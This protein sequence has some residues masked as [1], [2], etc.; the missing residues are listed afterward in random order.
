MFRYTI[1]LVLAVF[2]VMFS[3]CC[4]MTTPSTFP[5]SD[6]YL[7]ND[8]TDSDCPECP[9]CPTCE[10]SE[11][12]EVCVE[13]LEDKIAEC[14]SKQYSDDDECLAALAFEESNPQVCERIDTIK[15]EKNCV[16]AVAVKTNNPGYCDLL[17]YSEKQDCLESFESVGTDCQECEICIET[18]ED[19]IDQCEEGYDDDECLAALAFEESNPQVCERIGGYNPDYNQAQCIIAIAVKTNKP[20]Y[21]DLLSYIYQNDCYALFE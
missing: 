18:L 21:C 15:D 5:T 2:L 6:R 17:S 4:S 19:K 8:E 1:F 7:T 10:E 9:E 3:G 12:C 14:E 11:E 16:T 13:T 20:G